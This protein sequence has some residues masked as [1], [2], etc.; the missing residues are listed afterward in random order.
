MS[1]ADV[2][3][4]NYFVTEHCGWVLYSFQGEEV[5]PYPKREGFYFEACRILDP[6][7]FSTYGEVKY[8]VKSLKMRDGS[9]PDLSKVA[10]MYPAATRIEKVN[11]AAQR[12]IFG[13]FANDFRLSAI[14]VGGRGLIL[15]FYNRRENAWK[16]VWINLNQLEKLRVEVEIPVLNEKNELQTKQLILS[17]LLHTEEETWE[18]VVED[19]GDLRLYYLEPT[20]DG[21]PPQA[22]ILQYAKL[23]PSNRAMV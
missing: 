12:F 20:F 3:T 17:S 13:H 9:E 5:A 15:E 8:A 10:S 6:R 2:K 19:H 21:I 7:G 1:L 4:T 23:R 16:R 18:V 14:T 11:E 22:T